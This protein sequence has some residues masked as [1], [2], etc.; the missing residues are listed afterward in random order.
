MVFSPRR[1]NKGNGGTTMKTK[2]VLGFAFN[3]NNVALILKN[4]PVWQKGKYNGIGG[5][6]EDGETPLAAMIREFKEETGVEFNPWIKFCIMEFTEATVHCFTTKIP[7]LN[8]AK[9][10]TD[11]EVQITPIKDV[12]NHHI[13]MIDNIP[14]LIAMARTQ[15]YSSFDYQIIEHIK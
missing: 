1:C 5:H 3:R 15:E 11:E 6:I 10:L 13:P 9:S 8:N 7:F 14:W 4:R 2:Y 12:F